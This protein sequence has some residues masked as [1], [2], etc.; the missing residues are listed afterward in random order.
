[1]ILLLQLS[2][3]GP[4]NVQSWVVRRFRTLFPF[5]STVH[6]TAMP[7]GVTLALGIW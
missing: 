4:G 1:M 3:D 2:P 7:S 6:W 5:L